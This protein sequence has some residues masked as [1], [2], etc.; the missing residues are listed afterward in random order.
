ML[1]L[2]HNHWKDLGKVLGQRPINLD[3]TFFLKRTALMD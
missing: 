2:L 3:A 1:D